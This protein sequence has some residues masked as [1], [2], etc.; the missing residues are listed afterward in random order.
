MVTTFE[1]PH[2]VALLANHID[3]P[4]P[5]NGLGPPCS[6]GDESHAVHVNGNGQRVDI[7][8]RSRG[9]DQRV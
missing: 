9:N 6:L 7:A 4:Y 3:R 8:S 1:C 2:K 5:K